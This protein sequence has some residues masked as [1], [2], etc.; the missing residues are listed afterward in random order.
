M[1]TAGTGTITCAGC[2]AGTVTI[3]GTGN[4][5]GGGTVTVYNLT[6]S[7]GTQTISSATTVSNT[8]TT[9]GTLA[10]SSTLTVNGAMA[11]TGSMSMTGTTEQRVGANQNFGTT[12][13]ANDWSFATLIFSNSTGVSKTITTQ[14]GGSGSIIAT[15]LLQVGKGGD[16]AA[17]VL[18]AGNRTWTLSGT[19]GTP[20]T[21]P[22]GSIT[23]NTSTFNYTGN[24]ASGNTTISNTSYYNLTVNNASETWNLA[25]SPLTVSNTLTVTAGTLDL[26]TNSATIGTSSV[27]NS[28]NI[29]V[30]GTLTQS[31]SGTTT[32]VTSAAGTNTIGG[33]GTLTFYNL[34]LAPT[35]SGS[36]VTLGSAGSQTITVSNNLSIGDGS[37]TVTATANTNNP[38]IDVNGSFTINSSGTFVAPA[39]ANFTI[40]GNMTNNGTFTANN[41]TVTFDGAGTSTLA[42][43]GSPAITFYNLKSI[44]LGK[45]LAFTAGETFTTNGLLTLTDVTIN[46]TTSSQWFINHQGTES[47]T[48][49]TITNSGCDGASTDITLTG[50]DV[51]GGNN[52][53][54]WVFAGALVPSRLNGTIR[55]NGDTRIQ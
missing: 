25:A 49:T 32:V 17:T 45:A 37:H 21:L 20:L 10:G 43:S 48:G 46:S 7:S 27:T 12:S 44:T 40:A 13:G 15:T 31:A 4:I 8:L 23:V 41:G 53:A 33:S 19:T 55:V 22:Q 34:S 24:Y 29:S 2:S 39:S 47:V 51:N 1:S 3:S 5:G 9:N 52:G 50:T 26:Q 28:G 54:C 6:S 30:T 16:S 36:T 42:G 38:N 11:G 35:V 18:D 14:T